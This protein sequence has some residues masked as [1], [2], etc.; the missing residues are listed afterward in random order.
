MAN[1]NNKFNND[2]RL[3]MFHSHVY[4]LTGLSGSGKSTLAKRLDIWLRECGY[5]PVMLDGDTL[6]EL[7]HDAEGFD[8]GS[9]LKIARFNSRLCKF[10]SQQKQTVI[11]PTISLFTEIQDWNRANIPGYIE[12]FLDVSLDTV[13]LRDPKGIYSAFDHSE[14]NNVVGLDITAEFPENPDIHLNIS[15]NMSVVE[16]SEQLHHAIKAFLR[17]G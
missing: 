14:I 3:D 13:R 8:L 4:W 5:R 17:N 1:R 2:L 12:I 10:L 9:R 7:L 11:C 6:R 15:E 16:C